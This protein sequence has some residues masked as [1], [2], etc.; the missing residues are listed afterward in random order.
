MCAVMTVTVE[1]A[2][3]GYRQKQV[4]HGGMCYA[5]VRLAIISS[6]TAGGFFMAKM[7]TR[8][9]LFPPS[10][11]RIAMLIKSYKVT[12]DTYVLAYTDVEGINYETTLPFA[13]EII[14]EGHQ[15]APFKD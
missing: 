10:G 13:V 12:A 15:K 6:S 4:T 5:I 14:E 11:K 7:L 2:P 3:D 9:T 8:L 1:C